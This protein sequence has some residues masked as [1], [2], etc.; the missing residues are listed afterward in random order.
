MNRILKNYLFGLSLLVV[1]SLFSKVATAQDEAKKDKPKVQSNFSKMMDDIA[2]FKL[3]LDESEKAAFRSGTGEY[4]E[5][6]PS[7][8]TNLKSGQVTQGLKIVTLY[9][10]AS[11][12]SL[13][14]LGGLGKSGST[15]IMES[16]FMDVNEIQELVDFFEKFVNPNLDL[17]LGKKNT[18]TYGFRST[19]IEINLVIAR[20]GG[21]TKELLEVRMVNRP[22]NDRY[23]WT[24]SQ[25]SKTAE[26]VKTLKYIL[27]KAKNKG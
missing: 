14:G 27:E 13:F 2:F 1:L 17:E 19:E 7:A 21:K 10:P 16:G 18:V 26:V 23:F 11:N 24:K 22:F 5:F 20:D 8:F 6:Y 4:V 12:E 9:D 25:V 15:K 3:E